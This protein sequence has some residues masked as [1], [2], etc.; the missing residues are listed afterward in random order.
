ML[1][2]IRNILWFCALVLVAFLSCYPLSKGVWMRLFR[3]A[4]NKLDQ[5]DE[6]KCADATNQKSPKRFGLV[7]II[8]LLVI[9]LGTLFILPKPTS[10]LTNQEY[11][12][13][14]T[15]MLENS[16][17]V[18]L[19][20][21]FSFDFDKAYVAHIDSVYASDYYFLERLGMKS[22]ID[23]PP[24]STNGVGNRILFFKDDAII[25]D[26]RYEFMAIYP[27]ET[28]V[29][30]FPDTTVTLTERQRDPQY[31]G[32]ELVFTGEIHA[33][34]E[35]KSTGTTAV[36]T[37]T[38]TTVT[39]TITTPTKNI[40]STIRGTEPKNCRLIIDGKDIT[41]DNYVYMNHEAR[42][43]LLP[44]E[45]VLEGLGAKFKWE[46][47]TKA[48]ITYQG[49]QYVLETD[50]NSVVTSTHQFAPKGFNLI[51]LSGATN[52]IYQ[53][54]EGTYYIAHDTLSYLMYWMWAGIQVDYEEATVTV[55]HR[56]GEFKL[57]EF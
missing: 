52:N 32:Y 16:Q 8:V 18:K 13:K 50:K 15:D 36:S 17:N 39:T 42:Y 7:C 33:G 22:K 49:D 53:M 48:T 3:R 57:P 26:F 37:T 45:A 5:F 12:K 24:S 56:E 41:T 21:V 19:S 23:L 51:R 44:F 29:W 6:P 54:I 31:N 27:T 43:V 4:G 20:D 46:T 38:T 28:D 1:E 40:R 10:Y 2:D 14:M 11:R 47:E 34:Y 55:Y 9:C 35:S 25:Y 30:I